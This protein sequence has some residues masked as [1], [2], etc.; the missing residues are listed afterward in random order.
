MLSEKEIDQVIEKQVA[1][2]K[3]QKDMILSLEIEEPV[4]TLQIA[5]EA[6][7]KLKMDLGASLC[8]AFWIL[9]LQ[10][11]SY[12][13]KQNKTTVLHLGRMIK[14]SGQNKTLNYALSL[15]PEAH[16]KAVA[17]IWEELA[18]WKPRK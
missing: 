16:R 15:L 5:N 12:A 7:S 17:D 6:K 14:I 11:I 10:K 9:D 2:L 13:A 1:A 8:L 3:I 4:P 18:D